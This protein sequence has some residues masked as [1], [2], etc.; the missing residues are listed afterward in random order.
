MQR[1]TLLKMSLV[2]PASYLFTKNAY[3]TEI[4]INACVNSQENS[5][6]IPLETKV[7]HWSSKTGKWEQSLMKQEILVFKKYAWA[8]CQ[9]QI[10]AYKSTN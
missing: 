4:A 6:K 1:R 8:D 7:L 2:I 3:C 9:W 5:H 10:N